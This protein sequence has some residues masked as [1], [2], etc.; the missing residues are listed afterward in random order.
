M[1]RDNQKKKKKRTNKQGVGFVNDSRLKFLLGVIFLLFA[2]Y[3]T[4][5]F[6]SYLFTWKTDNVQWIQ[7]FSGS[8]INVN[9]LMGKLGAT[10]AY[11]FIFKWMGLASFLFAFLGFL[12]GLKLLNIKLP[13]FYK[14]VKITLVLLFFFS[15]FLGFF[16]VILKNKNFLIGGFQGY[17]V[18]LWLSSFLGKIG[19]G[20]LLVF[21]LL[22]ITVLSFSKVWLYFEKAL[23]TPPKTDSGLTSDLQEKEEMEKD[24]NENTAISHE[25][26][27]FE[28]ESVIPD[29]EKTENQNS[30]EKTT[31]ETSDKTPSE[32]K[33]VKPATEKEDSFTL[34]INDTEEEETVDII[35]PHPAEEYDP[36]LNLSHYQF[37]SL[38]LLKDYDS[39][40]SVSEEELTANKDKIEGTLKNYG[41]NI[42]KI[43]ATIGPTIT[44][45]EIIPAPGVR[46]S[47]IKNLED[48]IALSLAALGIRIIAP[49]PGKGT[50]GIEVPNKK[51]QIVSMRSVI[52]SKKFQE[53]KMELPIAMGKTISNETYVFDLAKMPHLLVAGATGQG[54]SVGL[55]AIVTSLLYSK[56][57]TTLKFVMIDP[58]MVEFSLYEKLR[59][60]Y[61]AV[62]ESTIDS[63]E[64]I[65]TDIHKVIY[66]LQSL[67]Q[68]MEDRYQLLKVAH[69]KN[70]V[71]YNEKFI[72]RKLSPD[73][74]HRFLPYIVVV[75]DEFADLIQTAGKEIELPLGRIAQKARAIG[76][77]L[78]VATQRPSTD[79][80]TGVI[81][82]NFPGRIAFRVTSIVDSRTI[83]DQTGANQLIGKGDMLISRGGGDLIRIQCAFASTEEVEDLV[84][85]IGDQNGLDTLLLPDPSDTGSKNSSKGFG[86]D[87]DDLDTLFSEVATYVV[88]NQ[89]GSTSMIQRKFK[90]GYN[91]A[92]RIMDQLEEFGIV[93]SSD[94]SKARKVL[95]QDPTTL[96]QILE[97]L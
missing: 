61:L 26:P 38:D 45:Y 72:K 54:K 6:L 9:N 67:V 39:S 15:L 56:H 86:N 49:I 8:D 21:L 64:F 97:K 11:H 44:L 40:L 52:A 82:A 13:K 23:F 31:S 3:L 12:F 35:G 14:T 25:E 84:D 20:I 48:D 92:G 96:E 7:I 27:I 28:N 53:A 88:D 32:I 19:T 41:I 62:P 87:D 46:I 85:F 47:K 94:G 58:K 66:T 80:I 36:T 2:I 55:N 1:A 37:P 75:I 93:G 60:H 91:R 89:H 65:I 33:V 79:V 74:G 24:F 90:I 63:E 50:V 68:E 78:I 83:L 10:L 4:F 71:E 16:D 69:A 73:N 57:P 51:P 34:E 29:D 95:I 30:V 70:I 22:G 42:T 76:I 43:S 5:A 77:H 81:K 59:N 17:S 18:S